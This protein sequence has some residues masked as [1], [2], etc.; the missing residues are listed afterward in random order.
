MQCMNFK[1]SK[2]LVYFALLQYL[3]F[4][5]ANCNHRL[6]I[7]CPFIGFIIKMVELLSIG[8]KITDIWV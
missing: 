4:H 5:F 2:I 6:L 3:D 1:M 7:P 8:S